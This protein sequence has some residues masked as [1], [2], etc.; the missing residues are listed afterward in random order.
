MSD[1]M[2]PR[3]DLSQRCVLDSHTLNWGASPT[4]DVARHMLEGD[5]GEVT[6]IMSIVRHAPGSAIA[7]HAHQPATTLQPRRPFDFGE[8]RALGVSTRTAF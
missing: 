3:Y 6:R 8:K 5:G 2:A 1:K 7:S 4:P